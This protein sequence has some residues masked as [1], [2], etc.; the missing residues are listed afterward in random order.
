MIILTILIPMLFV[1][2]AIVFN[3]KKR[4][5]LQEIKVPVDKKK[6]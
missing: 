6:F 1:F 5:K 3:S 2:A 4:T